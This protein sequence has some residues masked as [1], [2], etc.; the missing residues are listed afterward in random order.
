MVATGLGCVGQGAR[1]QVVD[2]YLPAQGMGYGSAESEAAQQRVLQD[3]DAIPIRMYGFDT[4]FVGDQA[5]GY[6]NNVDHISGGRGS[7]LIGTTGSVHSRSD[8]GRHAVWLG[9]SVDNQVYPSRTVQNRTN[10]S[11]NLGGTYQFGHDQLD[12]IY[13]HQ[14]MT[15]MPT[16]LGAVQVDQPVPYSID[17]LGLSYTATTHGRLTFVPKAQ[18][19]QYSF[20]NVNQA[21]P[22]FSQTYRNRVRLTQEMAT[23]YDFA[24]GNAALVVFQGN[25]TRYTTQLAGVPGRDSNGFSVAAGYDLQYSGPIQFRF[26]VGYQERLYRSSFYGRITAPLFEARAVWTPTHLTT[27]TFSGVHGIEDSAYENVVGFTYTTASVN[28][29]HQYQRN[30]FFDVGGGL[31]FGNYPS[32]PRILTGTPVAQIGSS[33]QSYI[34]NADASWLLN[35]HVWLSIGYG[36]QSQGYDGVGATAGMTHYA[37]HSGNLGLHFTL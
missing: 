15:Q 12:A 19:S 33:Q 9:A 34:F 11:V 1:A 23:R 13:S 4:V 24:A 35:R 20:A 27:V 28:I 3:Y 26:I 2:T 32:T 18:I 21:N 8:W 22:I 5:F 17:S 16:D 36:F 31:Q 29:R 25:E 37:I 10:W 30:I 7:A 6:S 14:K